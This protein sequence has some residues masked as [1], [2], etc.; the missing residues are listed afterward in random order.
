VSPPEEATD[1]AEWSTVQIFTGKESEAIPPFHISG[2]E[3]RIFWTA[4]VEHPEYAV[5]DIL[6]YSHDKA[7]VLTKRISYSEGTPS[8]TV[9]IYEGGGDYYLK[10]IAANLSNWTITVEDHGT[11]KFT[12]TFQITKINYR[13]SDY[14]RTLEAG[15][16]ILEGDEYVEIKNQ[17]DSPQ[18]I[19][20]WVLKNITKGAPTFVFPDLLPCSCEWYSDPEECIEN[21]YPPRPC[22]IEPHKSIRVYTGEVNYVSGGFCFNYVLGDAWNNETP[23]TAVLYNPEGQEASRKS[24][25]ISTE[26][27]AAS[28]K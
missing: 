5:F 9:Y 18:N 28:G 16:K 11:Q 12:S 27:S 2:T 8:D 25:I 7:G 24:Y 23:D 20:G 14:K 15:H 26:N 3:W 21:C 4:D 19:A 13:G 6:V 10:V 22:E 1:E 17:S